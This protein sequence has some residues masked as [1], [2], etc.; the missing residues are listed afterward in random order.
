L[1]A[2]RRREWWAAF[3]SFPS[4]HDDAP[5]MSEGRLSRSLVGLF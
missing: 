3:E 1:Q 4:R 2:P 5:A